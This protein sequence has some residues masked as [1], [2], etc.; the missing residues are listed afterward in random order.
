MP[1]LN[2]GTDVYRPV[3]GN[4]IT[5]NTYQVGTSVE[6][7]SPE[8]LDEEWLFPLGSIVKC[9]KFIYNDRTYLRII[10]LVSI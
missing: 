2:E 1:L 5:D 6:G 8:Q 9:K 3:Y 10:E 4:L 7:L